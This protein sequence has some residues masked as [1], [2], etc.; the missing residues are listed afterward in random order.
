MTPDTII[1]PD[2][3]ILSIS[4]INTRWVLVPLN[5]LFRKLSQRYFFCSVGSRMGYN[6]LNKQGN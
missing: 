5:L 6:Q 1:V 3:R 2:L 4:R